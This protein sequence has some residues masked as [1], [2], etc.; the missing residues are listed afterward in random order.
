[1]TGIVHHDGEIGVARAVHGVG[2]LH[3]LSSVA[4]RTVEEVAELSPGPLWFQLYVSRDRGYVRELLGR[5]R[6]AGYLALVITV[7]VQRAG[8][9]ERDRRNGFT[10]PPR[11][12]ARS[13][14]QGLVRPR[15]SVDFVRRPQFLSEGLRRARAGGSGAG[16]PSLTA[17]INSQFDPG[18][19]WGEI[20]WLQE[21][22]EGPIVLKGVLR[23]EDAQQAAR[24]G[25]AGVIVSNHG[26]RQ[27]DHA[28]SSI[29]ALPGVVDAVG[30]EIE[31]YMDG[32]IR[33]GV[34][35]L[36]ALALGARACLSGR[37][38]VYGLGA[39]G[40][41]GAVRAMTLLVEELRLAMT[42]AGCRSVRELDRS[43]VTITPDTERSILHTA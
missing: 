14:A 11:I 6:S 21:Q 10:L 24:L 5:A 40:E 30:S 35:V 15:W 18:L 39:G 42:L 13:L 28:P 41:A 12:S 2:G 23:A 22:W 34:D 3:V 43:W 32:G 16:Q 8:A 19:G 38:L 1:M 31:V 4:S 20:S 7:D 27:L 36:K 17:I 9:R 29:S 33:R 25:V 26:G 37:A